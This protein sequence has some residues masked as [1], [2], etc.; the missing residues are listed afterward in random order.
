MTGFRNRRFANGL[1]VLE[2]Q[3]KRHF[4]LPA[5]CEPLA[6]W[7]NLVKSGCKFAQCTVHHVTS[8][9]GVRICC[10]QAA[11]CLLLVHSPTLPRAAPLRI[12]LPLHLR[13]SGQHVAAVTPALRTGCRHNL[14]TWWTAN[15]LGTH[16]THA[17][18]CLRLQGLHPTKQNRPTSCSAA[19]STSRTCSASPN[20]QT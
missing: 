13:F 5:T 17:V 14:K 18:I 10:L 20:T 12:R 1:E 6:F 2:T 4:R 11:A 8:L 19:S 3:F 16:S 9:C 7:S 15:D